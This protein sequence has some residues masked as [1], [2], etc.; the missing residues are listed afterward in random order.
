MS[1]VGK[2][3]QPI[4]G[5]TPLTF[6]GCC[7]W[8]DATSSSNFALSGS[9]VTTWYDLSPLSNHASNVNGGSPI[10]SNA[11]INTLPAVY[12][13]NAPSIG[14]NLTLSNSGV[15]GFM[16][17]RPLQTGIG[18]GDQRIFSAATSGAAD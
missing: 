12:F 14:G 2:F 6:G 8:L 9:A 11:V 7:L 15:T 16:V 17:V 1:T 4:S 18:R 5:F 10:L 3:Q 13:S